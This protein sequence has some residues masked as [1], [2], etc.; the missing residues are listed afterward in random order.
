MR[1]YTVTLVEK[2]VNQIPDMRFPPLRF[3]TSEDAA[4]AAQCLALI[5]LSMRGYWALE[6]GV[7]LEPDL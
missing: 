3:K 5:A 4:D 1:I 6:F 7:G 2:G